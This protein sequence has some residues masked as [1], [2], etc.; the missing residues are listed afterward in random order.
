MNRLPN[1]TIARLLDHTEALLLRNAAQQAFLPLRAYVA[2]AVGRVT[3][4]EFDAP[5]EAAD[6]EVLGAILGAEMRSRGAAMAV[7]QLS[8]PGDGTKAETLTLV[9]LGAAG[10]EMQ[11]RIFTVERKANGRITRL[12]GQQVRTDRGG[13]TACQRIR[14]PRH[15]AAATPACARRP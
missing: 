7:L 10:E 9:G 3:A 1:L 5:A 4:L 6:Y 12:H 14:G 2:D 13:T 15:G 8:T 11:R